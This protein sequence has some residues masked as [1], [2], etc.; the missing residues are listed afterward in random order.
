MY[1]FVGGRSHIIHPWSIS[2]DDRSF[3]PTELLYQ[4]V[5]SNPEW[6]ALAGL[7]ADGKKDSTIPYKNKKISGASTRFV[8]NAV[9]PAK[10]A[11]HEADLSCLYTLPQ[12]AVSGARRRSDSPNEDATWGLFAALNM[13]PRVVPPGADP[14]DFGARYFWPDITNPGSMIPCKVFKQ[15]PPSGG[16]PIYN[17][18]P[19]RDYPMTATRVVQ[20]ANGPAYPWLESRVPL[21]PEYLFVDYDVAEVVEKLEGLFSA[22]PQILKAAFERSIPGYGANALQVSGVVSSSTVHQAGIGAGP[23]TGTLPL[24][25]GG[26]PTAPALPAAPVVPAGP[27]W[28]I[29]GA[30]IVVATPVPGPIVL[31]MMVTDPGLH[32]MSHDQSSGWVLPAQ[33]GIVAPAPKPPTPP[34]AAPLPP[35]P[36]TP[37]APPAAPL[38]PAAP[39]PSAPPAATFPAPG[40]PAPSAPAPG[41]VAPTPGPGLPMTPPPPST[42]PA[43]S[44]PSA[45]PASVLPPAAP[46]ATL[47]APSATPPSG[48][49]YAPTATSLPPGIVTGSAEGIGG[50]DVAA[51]AAE[52]ERQLREAAQLPS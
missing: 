18:T 23:Q 42:P 47:A 29:S 6:R 8:V 12:T 39:A 1:E 43:S 19:I 45:P 31:Q 50:D 17:M 49:A 34:P 36:P 33:L 21:L 14:Y 7:G 44:I 16:N 41:G 15:A 32:V 35:A 20:G 4:A 37:P 27:F 52:L 9:N 24:P 2:G 22:Y 11:E 26:A 28:V 51:Q 10:V 30:G 38:P 46:A 5:R 3:N 40:A 13:K 48:A 25:T